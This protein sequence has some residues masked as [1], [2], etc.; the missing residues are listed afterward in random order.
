MNRLSK[1]IENS[2]D[3]DELN[4]IACTILAREYKQLSPQAQ[5]ILDHVYMR[6]Q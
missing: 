1:I 5:T 2:T 4:R 6:I 3:L